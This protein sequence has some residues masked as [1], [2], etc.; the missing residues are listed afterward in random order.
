MC[1]ATVIGDYLQQTCVPLTLI[2][3]SPG[4]KRVL[5]TPRAPPGGGGGGEN[6]FSAFATLLG[7]TCGTTLGFR[8]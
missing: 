4:Q 7:R 2:G 5:K 1:D 8:S 3:D 6:I